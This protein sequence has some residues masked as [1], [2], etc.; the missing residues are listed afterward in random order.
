M[1]LLDGVYQLPALFASSVFH[2][3]VT[4]TEA[5]HRVPGVIV[6]ATATSMVSDPPLD[7]AT[8]VEGVSEVIPQAEGEVIEAEADCGACAGLD[9][10]MT[11]VLLAPITMLAVHERV[12]P[13]RVHGVPSTLPPERVRGGS[14]RVMVSWPFPMLRT[15]LTA[16]IPI[17]MAHAM[18]AMRRSFRFE[19]I[20]IIPTSAFKSIYTEL[21]KA[22]P[23]MREGSANVKRGQMAIG[24]AG[25]M[26]LVVASAFVGAYSLGYL[27]PRATEILWQS[28]SDIQ[29]CTGPYSA[30]AVGMGDFPG[31]SGCSQTWFVFVPAS[32]GGDEAAQESFLSAHRSAFVGVFMD[33]FSA[34]S[35]AYSQFVSL[36]GAQNVCPVY[37][38]P[39]SNFPCE[40]AVMSPGVYYSWLMAKT[41]G[42]LTGSAYFVNSTNPLQSVSA[43]EWGH[44]A[45][46][47]FAQ[48][49]S[50]RVLP[51]VYGSHFAEWPY[52]IPANYIQ[53]VT[54]VEPETVVWH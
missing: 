18:V 46:W 7:A 51:L 39:G 3:W 41:N 20:F 14:T 30:Q 1:E 8:V 15:A 50:Q 42:S 43:S 37:Y 17:P 16:G 44:V 49:G 33:D 34:Q 27:K 9:R 26:A 13:L 19:G 47:W 38:Y 22:R 52:P 23:Q 54:S 2:A 24:G 29:A 35:N 40:V 4:E 12:E 25:I 6:L 31:G 10:S 45:E 21:A 32:E 11:T 5:V 53:G 28:P 36:Y 48:F